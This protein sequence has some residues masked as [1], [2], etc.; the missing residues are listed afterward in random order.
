MKLKITSEKGM[1][2]VTVMGMTTI[3]IVMAG[4]LTGIALLQKKLNS[5]QVARHTALHVAEAGV[6]YYRW[7]LAH[8]QSDFMDG[9]GS[10]PGGGGE[11]YGPYT[12]SFS[13][14]G[15]AMTGTYVLE[16]TPPPT[17]S[18]IVKI[19][20]TG[21]VDSNPNIKRTI[22]VRYG[23]PSLA[24]FSFLTNS[25]TWF[26]ESES[27]VGE[28]HSNGGIRMDGT[29]DALI[30]SARQTYVCPAGQACD[31]QATCNA[32][33]TWDAVTKCTCPGIWGEGSG[34]SLWT[35]PVTTVDFN[36]ITADLGTLKTLAQDGGVYLKVNGSNKGY[37]ITFKSNGHF[38]ARLISALN[39]GIQQLND[40]WSGYSNISE[41]IR[42]EGAATDYA[43]PANGII[44]I[45][46][47]DA[48][49]EGTVNGRATLVAATLPA[50]AT[51]YRSIIINSNIVYSARNGS[52]ILGLIAQK[53]VKVPRHAPANLTIDGFMLAQNGRVFR[54]YYNS[55]VVKSAI[56]VYGGILTNQTWT[57]S[58]VNGGGTVTD[59]YASTTS[60]YDPLATFSPPPSFPT[61][62]EY[63][64][65][66]WGEE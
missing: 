52:N 16:I 6:N 1:V 45:E 19:R 3:F 47:G 59:G 60:I 35:Y 22:E 13:S 48:Y 2:L 58:W 34:S 51:K 66:S 7:H 30:T 41:S 61:S 46:D 26:G 27:V 15:N 43:I 14:P 65:I 29:N 50:Q 49:V 42:T 64:F 23:I 44:F 63:T 32:P 10:D 9:T 28:M 55:P 38:D 62:G 37:H 5:Q 56:E 8:A 53:D 31:T 17:G 25:D 4:A 20:S 40:T 18:T 54:N 12:H 11:P 21:W 24:K 39:N 36:S 57:W 33:C